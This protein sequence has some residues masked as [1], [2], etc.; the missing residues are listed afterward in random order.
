M[1]GFHLSFDESFRLKVKD[2]LYNSM[3]ERNGATAYAVLFGET[4]EIDEDIYNAY[5]D[6]GVLH[7]LAVSGLNVTFVPVF[8]IGTSPTIVNLPVG[9]PLWYS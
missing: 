5:T 9:T 1:T 8:S 2:M 3:G 7:L 6:A 4:I